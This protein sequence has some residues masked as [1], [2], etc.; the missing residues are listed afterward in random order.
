MSLLDA[1]ARDTIA[2]HC[3]QAGRAVPKLVNTGIAVK[4]V[5]EGTPRM[6]AKG[7]VRLPVTLNRDT[8]SQH[9]LRVD[10]V[11][12]EGLAERCQCFPEGGRICSTT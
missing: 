5:A 3:K 4:G 7:K 6:P 11:V 12:V 2:E 10:F 1:A 8:S 9:T